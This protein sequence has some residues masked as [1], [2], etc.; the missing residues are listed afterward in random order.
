MDLMVE[1]VNG[2]EGGEDVGKREES[3]TRTELEAQL[4][5]FPTYVFQQ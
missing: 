1:V 2:G 4:L 5:V 3:G